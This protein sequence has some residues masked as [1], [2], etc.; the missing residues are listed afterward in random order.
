MVEFSHCTLHSGK[1][2]ILSSLELSPYGYMFQGGLWVKMED[3][4]EE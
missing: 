3:N 2:I 4:T 1:L